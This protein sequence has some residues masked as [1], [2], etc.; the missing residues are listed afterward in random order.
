MCVRAFA[1]GR[2]SLHL[3]VS[4]AL[5]LPAVPVA[6][7]VAANAISLAL[8]EGRLLPE[9]DGLQIL[10]RVTPTVAL[11]VSLCVAWRRA[12][13]GSAPGESALLGVTAGLLMFVLAWIPAL[14]IVA[15]YPPS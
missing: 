6:A 1:K 9:L 8:L 3:I 4:P 15:L 12:K 10:L 14:I 7:A 13:S 5:A 2:D 11:L